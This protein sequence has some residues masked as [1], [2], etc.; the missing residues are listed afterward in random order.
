LFL[1][2]RQAYGCFPH[3]T[4]GY[5]RSSFVYATGSDWQVYGCFRMHI[6]PKQSKLGKGNPRPAQKAEGSCAPGRS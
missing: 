3:Q 2:F 5:H 4:I 6:P 1:E